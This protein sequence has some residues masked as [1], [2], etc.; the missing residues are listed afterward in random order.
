[1]LRQ[2]SE[3]D[4]VFYRLCPGMLDKMEGDHWSLLSFLSMLYSTREI[5]D[6]GRHEGLLEAKRKAN[7]SVEEDDEDEWDEDEDWDEGELDEEPQS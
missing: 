1:M 5:Y 2:R 3:T 7:L 6:E 4:E